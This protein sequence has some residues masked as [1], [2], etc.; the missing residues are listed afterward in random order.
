MTIA[1]LGW[2]VAPLHGCRVAK[3]Q[4]CG[5]AGRKIQV[6]HQRLPPAT[7]PVRVVTA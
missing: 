4:P 6:E 5:G 7:R 1:R 3:R 2:P